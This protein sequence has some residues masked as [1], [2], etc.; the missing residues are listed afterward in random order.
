[1]N[2]N[3][4]PP[5]L[6]FSERKRL[7]NAG[8]GALAKNSFHAGIFRSPAWQELR[9]DIDPAAAADLTGSITD[10][11]PSLASGSFDA[12]WSS[13]SLEHLAGHEVPSALSEFHRVLKPVG[14]VLIRCP[15]LDAV[16]TALATHGADHVAYVS[17]LGPVTPLDM[18]YGHSAS[19][20]DGK[21][22]MA[23]KTGF[24]AA[25]LGRLLLDAGFSTVLTKSEHYDLW[26]LALRANVDTAGMRRQFQ[27]AR[28]HLFDEALV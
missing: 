10:M 16:V 26:T 25:R 24:T 19:I 12:V 1:M 4:Q 15:D 7:L 3:G 23:H 18:L 20:R 5:A 9:V 22:H 11:R 2:S 8:S 17:A 14:F 21:H 27:N 6:V 28:F 13:H